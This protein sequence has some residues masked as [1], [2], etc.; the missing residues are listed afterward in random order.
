MPCLT[1]ACSTCKVSN[2]DFMNLEKM[3]QFMNCP[4]KKD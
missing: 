1:T 2:Q 3:R 4:S